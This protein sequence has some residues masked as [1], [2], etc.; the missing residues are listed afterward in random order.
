[1]EL[2]GPGQYHDSFTKEMLRFNRGGIV[3]NTVPGEK[4]KEALSPPSHH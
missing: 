4:A 3:S 2:L 1:M